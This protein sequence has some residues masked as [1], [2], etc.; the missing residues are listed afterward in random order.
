MLL[1]RDL[2]PAD[3][4]HHH[5]AGLLKLATKQV[6]VSGLEADS[7]HW[8]TRQTLVAGLFQEQQVGT[9]FFNLLASWALVATHCW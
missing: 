3:S 8:Q 9:S 1:S 7:R 2:L 4:K 6:S 5:H